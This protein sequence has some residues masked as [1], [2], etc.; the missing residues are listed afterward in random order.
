MNLIARKGKKEFGR[1]Q[2]FIQNILGEKL[3]VDA[4]FQTSLA[5]GVDEAASVAI[6]Q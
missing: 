5:G 1:E 2:N 3:D 6:W 4:G